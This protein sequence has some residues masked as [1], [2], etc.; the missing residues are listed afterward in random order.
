MTTYAKFNEDGD[1]LTVIGA[2]E[3]EP[4]FVRVPDGSTP[5]G[6]WKNAKGIIKTRTDYQFDDAVRVGHV[7]TALQVPHSR[8]YVNGEPVKFPYTFAEAGQVIVEV[9]GLY[10]LM[11][12]VQVNGYVADRLAAYPSI[13][14]QLDTLFHGGYDEWK[15]TI[16]EVKDQFPK[17]Q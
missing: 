7:W 9:K 16:Q 10:R 12:F 1:C 4:G 11:K 8:A 5:D 2:K 14:E 15:A 17:D 3:P 6:L 13:Q